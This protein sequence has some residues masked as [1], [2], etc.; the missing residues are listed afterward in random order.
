MYGFDWGAQRI[1]NLYRSWNIQLQEILWRFGLKSVRELVGR[2]D[3]LVHRDYSN[4]PL[5]QNEAA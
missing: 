1:I 2:T 5:T 3:L 4:K